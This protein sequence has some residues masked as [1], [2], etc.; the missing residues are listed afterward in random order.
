MKLKNS[1]NIFYIKLEHLKSIYHKSFIKSS[2]LYPMCVSKYLGL[3]FCY[4]YLTFSVSRTYYF[5][6]YI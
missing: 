5:A 3:K 6:A 2:T 1:K 4:Y